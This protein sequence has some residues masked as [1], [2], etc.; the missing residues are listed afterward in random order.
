MSIIAAEGLT[1]Q[2][3]GPEGGQIDALGPLD[4][5]VTE[6]EFVCIVGPSGC[7]K[8]TFLRL[9]AGLE[10]ASGG[11]LQL[12]R[13]AAGDRPFESMVFQGDSTFPWMTVFDNVGYGLQVRGASERR[14]NRTVEAMLQL[15]GLNAFAEAYPFQLSGGMRQRVALARALANDP[16]VLLMDEPFGA[17][18]AQNRILLQEELLRIWDDT[19]KT[20]LFVTHSIDEALLL[21][22]RVLLMSA[23]PGRIL[24][25][26]H[27]PFERPRQLF[28]LK[29]ERQFGEM[30]HTIWQLLRDEVNAARAQREVG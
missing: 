17:L 30:A 11:S 8:S 24:A 15:V 3:V 23:A 19:D 16:A 27:V 21:A 4:L 9:V 7:G 18:D 25:E 10:Q 26:F 1:K 14:I 5:S 28:E 20:V 13:S 22:D 12:D 29:R 2:F 6:G